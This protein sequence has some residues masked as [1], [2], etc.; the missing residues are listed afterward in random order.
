MLK[1]GYCYESLMGQLKFLVISFRKLI[2]HRMQLNRGV[3]D[4][5]SDHGID[6]TYCGRS[7][8]W[9]ETAPA[10]SARPS[11]TRTRQ[12][13]SS[14]WLISHMQVD[15]YEASDSLHIDFRTYHQS[16]RTGGM[17]RR[18]GVTSFHKW[19]VVASANLQLLL[20]RNFISRS[21]SIQCAKTANIGFKFIQVTG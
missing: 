14:L 13:G 16:P 8:V 4:R 6:M 12:V 7:C 5:V 18:D 3:I 10:E 21:L 2:L 17:A 1:S 20:C 15:C 19:H 9:A 11:H